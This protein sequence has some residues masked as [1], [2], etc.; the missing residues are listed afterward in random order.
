[1]AYDSHE[2]ELRY[3]FQK[4]LLIVLLAIALILLVAGIFD[5]KIVV[6][7]SASQAIS[8]QVVFHGLF[9]QNLGVATAAT[10]GRKF[11]TT[12]ATCDQVV[13]VIDTP[14]GLVCVPADHITQRQPGEL[15]ILV[16]QEKYH[17][18]TT[19]RGKFIKREYV[20]FEVQRIA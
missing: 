18:T 17:T 11:V 6:E 5:N 13:M 2:A 10:N 4:G 19:F 3:R 7:H 1:M 16:Y 12:V 8:G 14:V 15:V 20:G 9:T